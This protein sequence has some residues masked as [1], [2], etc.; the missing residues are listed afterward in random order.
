MRYLILALSLMLLLTNTG[1][2]AQTVMVVVTATPEPPA[3]ATEATPTSS[4]PSTTAPT[5]TLSPPAG[6]TGL[7][8]P[9][10]TPV[11]GRIR[12]AE[13]VFEGGRMF[14]LEPSLE[15]WVIIEGGQWMVY[16][17]TFQEG[18][19]EYDPELTPPAGL[20]QP[21]RGFGKVWRE[22]EDVREG[23]GWAKDV[24]YGYSTAYRYDHGG[25]VDESGTYVPE[26]GVHTLTTLGNE[27]LHFY[28]ADSTWTFEG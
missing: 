9:F 18:Q 23:L 28:E 26:P 20:Q 21:I 5:L 15:I 22:H 8:E 13:Q 24:E 27:I 1:C 14:W 2:V 12:V 4:P 7:P 3:P 10:P 6:A 17:D 16:P 11:V 25:Y 19:P